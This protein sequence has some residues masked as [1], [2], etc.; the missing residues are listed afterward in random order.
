MLTLRNKNLAGMLIGYKSTSPMND[1]REWISIPSLIEYLVIALIYIS[2]ALI[3]AISIKNSSLPFYCALTTGLM[4]GIVITRGLKSFIGFLI[5]TT[6]WQIITISFSISVLHQTMFYSS[7]F[8]LSEG[9]TLLILQKIFQSH[10]EANSLIEQNSG[11]K[12]FFTIALIAPIPQAAIMT[13][14]LFNTSEIQHNIVF[15][16]LF[17]LTWLS[18]TVSILSLTP[19]FISYFNKSKIIFFVKFRFSWELALFLLMLFIPNTLEILGVIT[20]PYS[21]PIHYLVFPVI[22]IIAFRKSIK[23]LSFSLFI[24]YLATIYTASINHGIFFSNDPYLNASNIYYFVLFFLFISLILGVAVNEKRLA[25]ESLKKNYCSIEDEVAR[26]VGIFKEINDKLFEEIEQRGVVERELSESRNLLEEAQEVANIVSWELNTETEKIIWSKSALKVFGVTHETLPSTLNEYRKLIHP[27]DLDYSYNLISKIIS[28]PTSFESEIRHISSNNKV[29]YVLIRGQSFDDLG[30]VVKRVIGL[31]LDITDKKEIERQ[32]AEK[33]EKYRALFESNIDSVSVINPEDKTFVDVNSAFE[34][35]YGFT[36]AE[37]IGKPYS[38]ISSEIEETYSAIDNAFRNGSHRVRSRV[39]KKK[40]GE[41]FY[42]EGIFVKFIA[43]GKP[44]IF[45]IS[46]DITKRKI[47][48]K[49]LAEQEMQFRLFF[50]SDLIGMAEITPKKE[51]ITFNNKLCS[52]LG[53]PAN[54]LIQ[55]T[56]DTL[57]HPDDLKIEM[58]LFNDVIVHKNSAYSIEKRFVR[59]D[60]SSIY[61]KVAVKAILNPQGQ[62]THLVKL[63]EDISTRKQIE[64]DLL[65]SRSTLRRAQQI[66]KLGSWSWTLMY[67]FISLNDEAYTLL[68]WKKSQGPFNIKNFI[69]LV[70]PEKRELLEKV[71]DTAKKGKKLVESIEIPIRINTNEL[72]YILLNIGFNIGSSVDVSEVVATMADITDIKKAEIALQE[73]N[74]LKDQLFSIIAHDLKGPIGTINQMITYIANDPDSIDTETRNDLIVSLKDTSQETYN[75]L[76]NLLDWAKSQGQISYKPENTLLKSSADNAIAL[77]SGMVSPKNITIT[78]SIDQNLTAYVDPYMINTVF[79][80]L[81]SN[82]IKF[83][84]KGGAIHI[85]GFRDDSR[86]IIKFIDSGIGIPTEIADKIFDPSINYTSLGTNNEKGTGLGLKLV[87]KLINRN[88]GTILVESAQNIGTTF[89]ITLSA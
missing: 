2:A 66:A 8:I 16:K 11:L 79:R 62:I 5:G 51:W 63:I 46:Q 47:A 37:I 85:Q 40:N 28:T 77:L 82:A 64:K 75:L 70:E 48:E 54:E 76:E 55:K 61:C 7:L 26:Q 14:I 56:W 38:L 27:D 39:H 69:E 49:T 67:N 60:G 21:F 9:I 84:P 53:Y 44:L 4:A 57:T 71:I 10:F 72:R 1:K 50:E 42:A 15:L 43:S 58:K 68:G 32:I 34:Q 22:F 83:T 88:G 59:K 18:I 30:G 86:V 89:T 45:I 19:F 80:N 12:K 23:A 33:E 73:A 13:I 25:F 52:I 3:T 65:E 35:R 29:N 36:K 31:S 24:F 17:H 81:I 87:K 78:N 6:L 20:P 74:S 41:E